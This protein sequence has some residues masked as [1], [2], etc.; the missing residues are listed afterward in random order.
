MVTVFF[1]QWN[2]SKGVL[3]YMETNKKK[4][5]EKNREIIASCLFS[6]KKQNS[7]KE[8]ITDIPCSEMKELVFL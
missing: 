7:K 6:W 5:M 8:R 2:F 3:Y 1:K 4:I